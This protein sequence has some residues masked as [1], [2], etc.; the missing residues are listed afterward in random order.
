MS[1]LRGMSEEDMK[2]HIANLFATLTNKDTTVAHL[3]MDPE[4]W[5]LSKKIPN[6]YSPET[7]KNRFEKGCCGWLWGAYVWIDKSAEEMKAYGK[8]NFAELEKDYP[9]LAENI[10][11]LE[12][13]MNITPPKLKKGYEVFLKGQD[14]IKTLTALSRANI[15]SLLVDSFY[16]IEQKELKVKE[17]MMNP[18]TYKLIK[19]EEQ[20]LFNYETRKEM[21]MQAIMAQL[22]G[23]NVVVAREIP[24]NIILT[25]SDHITVILKLELEERKTNE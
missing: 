9:E 24:D 6:I 1:S 3:V 15:R 11:E 21:I 5:I 12:N 13:K 16:I 8:D 17:I 20:H 25:L 22:W 7:K 18:Q 14:T 4:D 2:N 10:K 23:A 19:G